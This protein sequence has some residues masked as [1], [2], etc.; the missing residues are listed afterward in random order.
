ML[1]S[2]I[3]AMSE[4]NVI[5]KDNDLPW[6]LSNDLKWF[7]ANTTGKPIVM[8]RKNY[9][10]I[11]RPLPGRHN[12]IVTRDESYAV[13]GATVVHS[14]EAAL[15]AAQ[16]THEV[17][18]IGGGEIYKQALPLVNKLYLTRV[19]ANIDGD[20]FFPELNWEEWQ[21]KSEEKHAADE[22]HEHAFTFQV[23]E[24]DVGES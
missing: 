11:G 19:H 9:E 23:Y 16:K 2:I 5:G 8:G 10:S 13:E 24:R 7:K 6:R 14:L 15:H 1:I 18:I 12:I 17:M 20:V 22:K 3:V 21:M 4:N